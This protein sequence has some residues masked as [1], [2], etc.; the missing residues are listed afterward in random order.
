MVSTIART[1]ILPTDVPPWR[2]ELTRSWRRRNT[3]HLRSP[4]CA[5]LEVVNVALRVKQ[6]SVGQ[7]SNGGATDDACRAQRMPENAATYA[8]ARRGEATCTVVK[9]RD[10]AM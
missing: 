5:A 9:G 7:L 10:S 8:R 1:K 3:S 2:T 4:H 6:P